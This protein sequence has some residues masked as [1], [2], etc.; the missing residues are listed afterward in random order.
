[1]N[2]L[3]VDQNY[4][5]NLEKSNILEFLDLLKNS[6]DGADRVYTE[7]SCYRLYLIL[8]HLYPDASPMYDPVVGHVYSEINGYI[9]DI[10]GEYLS[11]PEKL[12]PLKESLAIGQDP[13]EWRWK[14][15]YKI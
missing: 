13:M 5:I 9:Y 12:Q 11:N 3:T 6:F 15:E 10:N 14:W 1:M 2:A 7:G 4:T 8:K